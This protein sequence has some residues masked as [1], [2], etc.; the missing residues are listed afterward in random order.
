MKTKDELQEIYFESHTSYYFDDIIRVTDIDFSN[1]LLNKKSN[2]TWKYFNLW[3][4]IHL[5]VQN[6]WALGSK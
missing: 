1:L 6:R 4:L 2:K 3:H 5:R